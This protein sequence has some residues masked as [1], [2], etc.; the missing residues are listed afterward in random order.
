LT[1]STHDESVVQDAANATAF[2]GGWNR[3]VGASTA[4][5]VPAPRGPAAGDIAAPIGPDIGG[6]V[7]GAISSALHQA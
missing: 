5:A 1:T 6:D 3:F 2:A 7:V 4:A